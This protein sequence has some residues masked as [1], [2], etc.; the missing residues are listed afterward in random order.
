MN[1]LL[2]EDEDNIRSFIKLNLIKEGNIVIEAI[3]GEQ[4]ISIINNQII[5]IAILDIMVPKINGI[6]VLKHIKKTGKDIGTIILSAKSLQEDKIQGL[7]HGADDYITKP[8]SPKELV[9]RINAL[10]RRLKLSSEITLKS[11]PFTLNTD[12]RKLYK[13]G[14]LINTTHTE[15]ELTKYF[16]ENRNIAISKDE[17][18]DEVW[19]RDYVGSLNTLDVNISRLRRKIEDDPANPM[20]IKTVWGYGYKWEDD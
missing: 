1:I 5:D 19:G 4:A 10:S 14:I 2:L 6:E 20:H 8:F 12:E 15:Y 3:D 16:L 17:I 9:L 7:L 11:E 18:F 13:D